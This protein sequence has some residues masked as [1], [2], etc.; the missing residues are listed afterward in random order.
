MGILDVSDVEATG[1]LFDVLEDTDSS[2]VV[3]TDDQNLSSIFELDQ[4][5]NFSSLKVQLQIMILN[6]NIFE[7]G[8]IHTFTE[9]CLLTSGCGYLIVLPS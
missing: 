8:E 3:T 7:I 1:V 4:T 2:D 9:S 5:L 6:I